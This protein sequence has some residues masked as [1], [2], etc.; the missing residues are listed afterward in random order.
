MTIDHIVQCPPKYTRRWSFTLRTLFIVVAALGIATGL[1]KAYPVELAL[2]VA[3]AVI[4]LIL[5][6]PMVTVS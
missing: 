4:M 6:W 5:I 2:F 1:A 3:W